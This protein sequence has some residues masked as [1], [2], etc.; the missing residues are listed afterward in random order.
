MCNIAIHLS[1]FI[2]IIVHN[3]MSKQCHDLCYFSHYILF[4]KQM[5]NVLYWYSDPFNC[6]QYTV[7]HVLFFTCV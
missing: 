5:T 3:N 1:L 7:R 4:Y 2:Y 6:H